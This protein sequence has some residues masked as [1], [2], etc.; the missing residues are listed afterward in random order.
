MLVARDLLPKY[1]DFE[2]LGLLLRDIRTND[3]F[4][5]DIDLSTKEKEQYD[6]IRDLKIRGIALTKE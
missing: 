3:L 4:T 1:F 2:G 6:F 5:Y